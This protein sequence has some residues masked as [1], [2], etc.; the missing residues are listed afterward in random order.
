M[1][2]SPDRSSSEYFASLQTFHLVFLTGLKLLHPVMP[3][4]TEE[5]YQRI[6]KLRQDEGRKDSI[7]IEDYPKAEEVKGIFLVAVYLEGILL[8]FLL[9][10]SGTAT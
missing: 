8:F 7:M 5:L 4:L 10:S 6:P 2:K 3:F 9:F 1:I